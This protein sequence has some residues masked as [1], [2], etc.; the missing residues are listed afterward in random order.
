MYPHS[1]Y[2][3]HLVP[4]IHLAVEEVRHRRVVKDDRSQVA[5]LTQK[6]DILDVEQVLGR[7]NPE[8]AHFA[9][10]RIAQVKQLG[11]GRGAEP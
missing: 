6:L 4:G 3:G 1:S 9:I 11:P 2:L 8:T 7:G 10:A 5:I